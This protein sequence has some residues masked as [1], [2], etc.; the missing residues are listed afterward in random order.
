[1]A[2]VFLTQMEVPAVLQ[3]LVWLLTYKYSLQAELG[4]NQLALR[5]HKLILLGPV[6]VEV[7]FNT[8]AAREAVAAVVA[9]PVNNLSFQQQILQAQYLLLY[10]LVAPALGVL[11][12]LVIIFMH[13]AAPA[14]R[15]RAPEPVVVVPRLGLTRPPLL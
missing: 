5:L 4:L 13:M 15:A 7:S 12:A 14:A 10:Q 3:Y 9:G 1:M 6:V 2:G 8:K 11:L